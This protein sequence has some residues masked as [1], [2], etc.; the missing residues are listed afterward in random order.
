[1]SLVS[2]LCGLNALLFLYLAWSF[3]CK[4][5]ENCENNLRMIFMGIMVIS[6]FI[7]LG[8]VLFEYQYLMLDSALPVAAATL[9]DDTQI[10]PFHFLL[11]AGGVILFVFLKQMH[12]FSKPKFPKL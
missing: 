6:L 12:L 5:R 3:S 1:M 8:E 11:L 9:V 4:S 7:A 10:A 2:F